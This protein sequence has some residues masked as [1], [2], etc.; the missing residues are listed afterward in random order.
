MMTSTKAL[1]RMITMSFY[2]DTRSSLVI[3]FDTELSQ[4][5]HEEA[6]AHELAAYFYLELDKREQSIQHFLLAH[7]KYLEWVS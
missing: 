4:F 1:L 2:S 6:L 5:V 7:E 3:A